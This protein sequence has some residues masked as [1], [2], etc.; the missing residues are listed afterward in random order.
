M[1]P[2]ENPKTP[3]PGALAGLRV[4]DLT[5]FMAGPYC[6]LILAEMGADVIKVERPPAGDPIREWGEK[7]ENNPQFAYINRGKRS[8]MLDLRSAEGKARL[9]SL[10]EDADVLVENFRPTTLERLDLGWKRLHT[11][12]PRLIYGSISGFGRH[13]PA[14]QQGG[15]DLIAQAMGGLMHVTGEADQPPQSVG[16]PVC[17]LAAGMWCALGILAALRARDRHGHGQ[18]VEVSL[19]EA[20]MAMG[21]WTMAGF[22]QTGAEPRRHGARHRQAAP[23]QRLATSDGHLIVGAGTQALWERLAS[24]L[25]HPEWTHDPR[26]VN[27]AERIAHADALEAT[28]EAVL[29]AESTA[30]WIAVLQA[31]DVP[32]GPVNSYRALLADP[33]V[34]ARQLTFSLPGDD[35][36]FGKKKG[37]KAE[38]KPYLQLRLPLRLSYT[39]LRTA[40]RAPAL[41]EHDGTILPE[42]M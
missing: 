5:Q 24:A 29:H 33:H 31:A 30:H 14:H 15:F 23:Y 28:L 17:D 12:F 18:L 9:F 27:N 36:F 7:D 13:G 38:E 22:L 10:L 6:T 26:F 11:R 35:R 21:S 19:L 37:E 40:H 2:K 32:C 34:Q 39:D 42:E 4:I 16:V 8:L 20:A 1:N 3:A 25:E 41:G